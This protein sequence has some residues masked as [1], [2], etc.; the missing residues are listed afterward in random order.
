MAKMI[1]QLRPKYNELRAKRIYTHA[2]VIDI[3]CEFAHSIYP[4]ISDEKIREIVVTNF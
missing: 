4:E 1:F 3:L 2:E